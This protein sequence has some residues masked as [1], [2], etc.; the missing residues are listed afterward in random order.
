MKKEV[1]IVIFIFGVCFVSLIILFLHASP[2]KQ[3]NGRFRFAFAGTDENENVFP[4]NQKRITNE[5]LKYKVQILIQPVRNI[6]AYVLLFNDQDD[7]TLLFPGDA[8][9]VFFKNW[10]NYEEY[11]IPENKSLGDYIQ[12]DREYKLHIIF[13]TKRLPVLEKEL[14]NYLTIDKQAKDDSSKNTRKKMSQKIINVLQTIL[15]SAAD[16]FDKKLP[17]MGTERQ[18]EYTL[19]KYAEEIS[20]KSNIYEIYSIKK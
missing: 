1:L 9:D 16:A 7:F 18:T 6:Y 17:I 3:N 15:L 12:K 20:F 2:S 11:Y 19:K 13:S 8:G 4:V 14:R 5:I 10:D